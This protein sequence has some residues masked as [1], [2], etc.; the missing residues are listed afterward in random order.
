MLGSK[1][2]SLMIKNWLCIQ[3]AQHQKMF[4]HPSAFRRWE[5]E[6][7][8]YEC[9]YLERKLNLQPWTTVPEEEIGQV[10]EDKVV[11]DRLL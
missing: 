1:K 4:P 11:S 10:T 3:G 6:I 9:R 7:E 8:V 5:R 2:G